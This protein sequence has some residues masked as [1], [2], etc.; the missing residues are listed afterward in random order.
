[1][2]R[3]KKEML[4]NWRLIDRPEEKLFRLQLPKT[5]KLSEWSGW[6][7]FL[8]VAKNEHDCC[9]CYNYFSLRTSNVLFSFWLPPL[10]ASQGK[11]N[12]TSHCWLPTTHHPPDNWYSRC[13]IKATTPGFQRIRSEK[14]KQ[15]IRIDYLEAT[16]SQ[17]AI[18]KTSGRIRKG[19]EEAAAH[20][21]FLLSTCR[22]V[23]EIWNFCLEKWASMHAGLD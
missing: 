12:F 16:R 10:H 17:I 18:I 11:T 2:K 9:S 5:T 4:T 1:M 20:K 19:E 15:C 21:S 7:G 8:R 14:M 3:K 6:S 23:C 13:E 22:C